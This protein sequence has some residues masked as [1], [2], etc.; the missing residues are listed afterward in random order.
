MKF[1]YTSKLLLILVNKD[2]TYPYSGGRED[3]IGPQGRN[4]QH[5]CGLWPL[6]CIA[7]RDN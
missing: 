3:G 2:N 5:T 6:E 1:I 7:G 4:I